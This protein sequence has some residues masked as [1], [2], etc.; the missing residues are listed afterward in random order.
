MITVI[1]AGSFG[2]STAYVLANSKE[3]VRLFTRKP[4][5]ALEINSLNH[6]PGSSDVQRP[7]NLSATNDPQDIKSAHR[8]ILAI[9]TQQLRSVL[10]E[11]SVFVMQKPVLLLQKGIEKSTL[12]LP[13]EIMKEFGVENI[14]VLSGPNFADEM[15][16]GLPTATTISS[17]DIKAADAWASLFKSSVF[18]PYTHTDMKGAQIGGAI[19]NIV[20][21]AC[22][23]V[24]GLGLGQNALSA[25]IT[26]GLAEMV[27]LGVAMGAKQ[28]TFL[29]LSGV[30]D[31]VLTCN[32][33]QSRNFRFGVSLAREEN[34]DESIN[35]TIEGYHTAFSTIQLAKKLGVQM[36]IADCVYQVINK[37][38]LPKDAVSVLMQRN[39]KQEVF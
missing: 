33:E 15:L 23:V 14:S 19:K 26:R 35:G 3:D 9:P 17:M 39:L 34:W 2:L 30:G 21:I 10:T 4:E 27:R 12:K 32:S 31:L 36:P 6:V 38:L 28:E 11:Y 18:R 5:R 22:G 7:E 25:I 1:G 8:I 20:A 16:N 29:G 13:F 24:K 37:K